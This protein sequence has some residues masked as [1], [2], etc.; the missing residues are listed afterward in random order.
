MKLAF[1]ALR[2][3][4]VQAAASSTANNNSTTSTTVPNHSNHSHHSHHG[5]SH[6]SAS[7]S[8]HGEGPPIAGSNLLAAASSSALPMP[9][10]S[11][12]VDDNIFKL[13]DVVAVTGT[14]KVGVVKYAGEVHFSDG[15]WIGIELPDPTGKNDGSVQGVKYFNCKPK[16]GL[17][18]RPNICQYAK[19][20]QTPGARFGIAQTMKASVAHNILS[21]RNLVSQKVRRPSWEEKEKEKET[22]SS[23][24]QVSAK[25]EQVEP[26]PV[27]QSTSDDQAAS[28]AAWKAAIA[29]VT[30]TPPR[31]N[32]PV[33]SVDSV[34]GEQ[35]ESFDLYNTYADTHI[36]ESGKSS[37]GVFDNKFSRR[38]S[39]ED[40]NVPLRTVMSARKSVQSDGQVIK[41]K[42]LSTPSHAN[43][44]DAHDHE[45]IEAV[46]SSRFKMK[47]AQSVRGNNDETMLEKVATASPATPMSMTTEGEINGLEAQLAQSGLY[48]NR[49]SPSAAT[50]TGTNLNKTGSSKF[51]GGRP[52]AGGSFS[53]PKRTELSSNVLN[54][55]MTTLLADPSFISQVCAR[56]MKCLWFLLAR[57]RYVAAPF[58]K[59]KYATKLTKWTVIRIDGWRRRLRA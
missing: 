58:S 7:H 5:H 13:G 29:Q 9:P 54:T 42:N 17:F 23:G 14:R 22:A 48:S 33:S 3:P 34:G 39:V 18:V 20:K 2:K 35:D 47:P 4:S 37:I 15:V 43:S 12:I 52:S 38:E 8:H 40:Y 6:G 11:P 53:K 28:I 1:S 45:R 46:F 51:F 21:V 24:G 36:D 59:I 55:I 41:P 31:V 57:V 16:H 19:G 27:T 25:L 10:V 30:V 26:V 56:F 44:S 49:T 50:G 32:E